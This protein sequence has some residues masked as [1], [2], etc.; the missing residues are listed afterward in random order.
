MDLPPLPFYLQARLRFPTRREYLD[1]RIFDLL[2]SWEAQAQGLAPESGRVALDRVEVALREAL[3]N[4]VEH[5]NRYHPERQITLRLRRDPEALEI[6]VEDE[7]DGFDPQAEVRDHEDP[8]RE[9]GRGLLFLRS[10][11]HQVD[12]EAG[13]TRVRLKFLAERTP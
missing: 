10:M 9:R 1:H 6:E 12:W 11:A 4:A 2:E 8:R 5:G 13:G 7:G 3:A